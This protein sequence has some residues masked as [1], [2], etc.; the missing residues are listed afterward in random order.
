MSFIASHKIGKCQLGS[1]SSLTVATV[2]LSAARAGEKR[3]HLRMPA[4]P[5]AALPR[6][7]VEGG[8]VQQGPCIESIPLPKLLL[9]IEIT[10]LFSTVLPGNEVLV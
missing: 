9:K 1:I 10:A 8:L 2:V 5:Q 7:I 3:L 4:R 6:Q